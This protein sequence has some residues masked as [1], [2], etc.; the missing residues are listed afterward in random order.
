MQDYA[1][2]IEGHP[3]NVSASLLGGVRA[4]YSLHLP[5]K[6][7]WESPQI[8]NTKLVTSLPIQVSGKLKVLA[9]IPDFELST[10]IARSVL[11]L[12]YSNKDIV[13]NLQRISVLSLALKGDQVGNLDSS[14]ISECLKDK[15]HQP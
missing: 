3:D 1:T 8:S 9:V 4:S 5:S 7:F 2:I 15:I 6:D 11:P 12:S 14:I 10:S 13:Y